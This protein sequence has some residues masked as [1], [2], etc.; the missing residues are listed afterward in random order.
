MVRPEAAGGGHPVLLTHGPASFRDGQG[1]RKQS[2]Q[3]P[4]Q[5][6]PSSGHEP[7]VRPAGRPPPSSA[8]LGASQRSP[9][10]NIPPS[11]LSPSGSVLASDLGPRGRRG[12]KHCFHLLALGLE[13]GGSGA[14]QTVRHWACFPPRARRRAAQLLGQFQEMTELKA[15]AAWAP[16]Q[17]LHECSP[18]LRLLMVSTSL[19][20]PPG[21]FLLEPHVQGSLGRWCAHSDSARPLLGKALVSAPGPFRNLPEQLPVTDRARR[22]PQKLGEGRWVIPPGG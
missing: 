10:R 13:G 2:C 21:R 8:E 12:H 14:G 18:L 16:G 1:S 19:G 20:R 4:K 15:P 5:E 9:R 6:N 17:A 11:P 3:D 22:K 7:G